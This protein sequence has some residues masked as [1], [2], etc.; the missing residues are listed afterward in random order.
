MGYQKKYIYVYNMIEMR[1]EIPVLPLS[2]SILH[3]FQYY[4]AAA[5]AHFVRVQP[6]FFGLIFKK[7][8]GKILD[9]WCRF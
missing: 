4:G 1:H 3:I 6:S 8:A 9:F 2:F 5:R 7:L